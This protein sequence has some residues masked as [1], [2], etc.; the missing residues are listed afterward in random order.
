MSSNHYYAVILA[1]GRG[2]R[3]WPLSTAK[4]PKQ[5]LS[6][7]A[8]KALLAQAV[9]RLEGL[10]PHERVLV[11]TNQDLVEATR[12]AAPYLPPENVVGEPVGRDT[13]P[14]VALS[15]ALVKARDPQ[16]V[17]CILTADHVIGNLDVFR[18]TLADALG[19]AAR[20]D[21]LITIGIQ[22]TEPATGYGYIQLGDSVPSGTSTSFAKARRF[23]E[24]PDL[25]TAQAYVAS[26]DYVWNSGMFIWSVAS[27]EK[28]LLQHRPG[29]GAIIETISTAARAGHLDAVLKEMFASV[30]KISIDYA[31][32]EKADNIIAARGTFAWDDVGSW[33]A[34][35]N[36]FPKDPAGNTLIGTCETLDAANNIVFSRDHL[37]ALLGVNNLIVVQSEGVTLVCPRDRAQDIKQMVVLLRGK[38]TYHEVL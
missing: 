27:I 20:K 29:I 19:I 21:V 37:T 24:K 15:A 35:E 12:R 16:G 25:T 2:E 4:R 1:G 8:E 11:V 13:A 36:H 17:F 38:G 34:L 18:A 31:V 26:G 3:F 6:L 7:V 10:I 32:M 33:T 9:D 28:A 14:A 5:L 23:V 30:E 22:P